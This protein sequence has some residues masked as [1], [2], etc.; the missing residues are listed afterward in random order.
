VAVFPERMVPAEARYLRKTVGAV[1]ETCSAIAFV[2]LVVLREDDLVAA[3]VEAVE[4]T[5]LVV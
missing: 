3:V 1:A 5:S 4:K 2:A